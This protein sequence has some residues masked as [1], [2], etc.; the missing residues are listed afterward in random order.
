MKHLN[1]ALTALA[2]ILLCAGLAAAQPKPGPAQDSSRIIPLKVEVVLSEYSGARRIS[3]LPYTFM[4]NAA[5]QVQVAQS[6]TARLHMSS[7]VPVRTGPNWTFGDAETNIDCWA[8][9]L[10]DGK[11]ELHVGVTRTS[12][13]KLVAGNAAGK[14]AHESN[15]PPATR[16]FRISSTLLLRVG[17]TD[18]SII[19][20][21]PVSG[22]VL[23]VT[24]A[25]HSAKSSS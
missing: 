3:S 14:N 22:H 1:Q 18:T 13:R 10:P 24:G 12:Y 19:A 9:T 25:L 23:R 15:L 16:L 11:Y 20:T 6:L 4:V 2:V 21:D 8:Q 5:G 7:R 17:Q